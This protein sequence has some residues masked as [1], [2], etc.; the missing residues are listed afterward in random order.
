MANRGHSV[1]RH[2]A[3]NL[4]EQLALLQVQSN[5]TAGRVI[6]DDLTDPRWLSSEGWVKMQQTFTFGDNSKLSIHYVINDTMYLMDDFK[7][8][9]KKQ[10]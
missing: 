4:R 1:G 7:F 6:L 8:I 9:I 2:E 5:P 10:I 3:L